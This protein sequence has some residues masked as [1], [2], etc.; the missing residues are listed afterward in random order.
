MFN[1]KR[2][3]VFVF[4][5]ST[6]LTGI[7]L[8]ERHAASETNLS[9]GQTI[10]IP[11]YSHV[12]HGH[13]QHP[14]N[15]TAS[16]SIRNVEPTASITITSVRYHDSTGKLLKSYLEKPVR[17][18]PLAST[19]YT[20]KE[21]DMAGGFGANFLVKW[22]SDSNVNKPVIECVMISTA[23]QQG[24]SFLTIGRAIEEVN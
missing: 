3:W 7:L 1:R 9:K 10:Y 12:Y 2:I 17:L 18:G 6:V 24:I 23:G 19:H 22:M 14:F 21:S 8:G 20:V 11:V 13:K 4:L 5:A 15:L 16:L